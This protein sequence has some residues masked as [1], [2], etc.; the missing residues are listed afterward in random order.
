MLLRALGLAVPEYAHIALV[1]GADGAPLSKR[2]GSRSVQDLRE[3][4][5]LP[6]AIQNYLAR[7]GHTYDDNSLLTLD[8]LASLFSVTRLHRAPARFDEAQLGYWQKET[9]R[10]T[11]DEDLWKWMNSQA[12]FGAHVRDFVPA[13]KEM[14]FV[15]AVR[16]NI[17]SPEEA[18]VWAG[19]LFSST[20][21]YDKEASVAIKDAG[22]DF[23][24]K[25][26]VCLDRSGI[27]FKDY[28]QKVEQATNKKGRMLFMPL[29]AA[30]TGEINEDIADKKYAW[31]HGPDMERIWNLLGISLVQ[32]RLT[33]AS[34]LTK[35]D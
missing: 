29:R 18:F 2:T 9:I 5:F 24:S 26:L 4:G 3:Q 8:Q 16:G 15:D 21:R 30:L 1:V 22:T 13:G 23:F 32:R 34:K 12:T 33:E 17:T 20:N 25:A 28:V 7:L 35:P 10:H 6:V 19:N 11:P 27:E 31:N 14:V